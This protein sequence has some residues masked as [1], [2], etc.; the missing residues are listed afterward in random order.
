MKRIPIVENTR[1]R[2]VKT[3]TELWVTSRFLLKRGQEN[4]RG[5]HHQFMGSLV[6]T[7]FTLEAYL[8]HI[9]PKVFQCWGDLERLSPKQKLNIIAERLVV[10]VNY[11]QRPWQVMKD[12]F[13]FRNDIAHGKSDT[14]NSKKDVPLPKYSEGRPGEFLQTKWEKYC[15]N[16]NA[17]K[18]MEDVEKI[19]HTFYEA[20]KLY[21]AEEFEGDYPF[22]P[23]IQTSGE[24]IKQ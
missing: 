24:T 14:L 6:I 10:N 1:E 11:G 13:G 20:G 21:R 8:N 7:A 22:I 16:E 3:Y 12:L 2:D 5:S 18:A 17:I 4:P 19:V 9:G 15:N 23:G